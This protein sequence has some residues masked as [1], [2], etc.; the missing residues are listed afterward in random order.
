MERGWG[1]AWP[2]SP[3]AARQHPSPS[4]AQ[5]CP[6]A[7][8]A[9]SE[10]ASTSQQV[11]TARAQRSSPALPPK[12]SR[13]ALKT[14]LPQKHVFIFPS[15]RSSG[16]FLEGPWPSPATPAPCTPH[17]QPADLRFCFYRLKTGGGIFSFPLERAGNRVETSHPSEGA[18]LA[19]CGSKTH[20][21]PTAGARCLHSSTPPSFLKI[22]F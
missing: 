7:T 17:R 4:T 9:I 20:R 22:L 8:K 19:P 2:C 1:P 16:A 15:P 12:S 5:P 14:P 6:G 13:F 3:T 18:L 11:P 10:F 21:C